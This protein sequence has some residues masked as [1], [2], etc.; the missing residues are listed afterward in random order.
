MDDKT[1]IMIYE[2]PLNKC[3]ED[4]TYFSDIL[5]GNII[6]SSEFRHELVSG[7]DNKRKMLSTCARKLN[8]HATF[9]QSI[10]H[11]NENIIIVLLFLSGI[12]NQYDNRSLL[13][14]ITKLFL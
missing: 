14:F 11:K 6:G 8:F 7:S 3:T 10:T 5:N 2:L 1:Y 9:Y 13:F 12:P 4:I